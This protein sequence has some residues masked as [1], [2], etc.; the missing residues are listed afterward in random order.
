MQQLRENHPEL[1]VKTKDSWA[2]ARVQSET[3]Q[4]MFAAGMQLSHPRPGVIPPHKDSGLVLVTCFTNRT[5]A[6]VT[7]M[8]RERRLFFVSHAPAVPGS[9]W[10]QAPADL[11]EEDR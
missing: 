4:W 10:K 6:N 2:P 7:Q 3:L 8:N 5:A 1:Q 11:L 9:A